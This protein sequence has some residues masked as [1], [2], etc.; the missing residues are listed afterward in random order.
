MK[1]MYF[2]FSYSHSSF[3]EVY[4]MYAYKPGFN[5]VSLNNINGNNLMLSVGFK[6]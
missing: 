1:G 6:F 3:D 4:G 2:D 5:E